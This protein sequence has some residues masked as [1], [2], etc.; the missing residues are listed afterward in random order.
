MS[1]EH[2]ATPQDGPTP[3]GGL[4]GIRR[5]IAIAAAVT[6]AVG[7]PAVAVAAAATSQ[8]G[9]GTSYAADPH[10]DDYDD[11]DDDDHPNRKCKT[12]K[13]RP[14][15]TVT[16][17]VT[18]YP[19]ATAT[20]T[21]CGTGVDSTQPN[22]QEQ[23]LAALVNGVAYAGR[24][25]NINTTPDNPNIV[26]GALNTPGWTNLSTIP[27]YPT[28]SRVCDVSVDANGSDVFYK[29]ITTAGTVHTLH[30]AG[31]GT[32][33]VCPAPALGNNPQSQWTAV[34]PQP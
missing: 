24:R 5:L 11:D 33:L 9:T 27:G 16:R 34:T 20:T 8:S 18:A 13:A 21:A 29:V 10:C 14:T 19:T 15:V 2:S 32:A 4:K 26:S 23:F 28:A 7:T 25:A 3:R 31:G 12:P 30:C 6:V 17:T 1:P 22:G